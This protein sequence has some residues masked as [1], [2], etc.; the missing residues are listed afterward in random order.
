MDIKAD[1]ALLKYFSDNIKNVESWFNIITTENKSTSDLRN[2]IA[3]LKTK[4]WRKIL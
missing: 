4:D 1:E 2:E 3:E